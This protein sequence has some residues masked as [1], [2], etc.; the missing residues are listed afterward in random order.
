MKLNQK[1][2]IKTKVIYRG[3]RTKTLGEGKPVENISKNPQRFVEISPVQKEVLLS[4]KM[5]GRILSN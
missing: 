1:Q 3:K 5:S 4:H 2:C